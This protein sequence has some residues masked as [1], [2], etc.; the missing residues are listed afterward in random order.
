MKILIAEP[1]T[2]RQ[3]QLRT[4]LSSLG[5]KS[6][7]I[8]TA[9]DNKAVQSFTRKKRYEILFVSHCPDEGLDGIQLVKEMRGGS[10]KSIPIILFST[11]MDRDL[12]LLSHQTGASGCL[13]YPFSVSDVEEILLKQFKRSS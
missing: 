12:V 3:R 8:E 13:G 7:E 6:A 10:N 1:D 5:N 4:I 2:N 9:N 11:K